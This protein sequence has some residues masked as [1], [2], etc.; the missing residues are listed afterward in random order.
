ML[1]KC[2]RL[3]PTVVRLFCHL[4]YTLLNIAACTCCACHWV[5]M[6]SHPMVCKKDKVVTL[7]SCYLV[8]ESLSVKKLK[9]FKT[10]SAT[11]HILNGDSLVKEYTAKTKVEISHQN[12]CIYL[13][14]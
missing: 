3:I 5:Y 2:M 8:V 1:N 13:I 6:Q 10:V 4:Y 11:P 9:P 14:T 7:L 12:W